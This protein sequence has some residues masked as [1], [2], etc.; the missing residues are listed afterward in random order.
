MYLFDVYLVVHVFEALSSTC[1]H[2]FSRRI[3]EIVL[4]SAC[5][6]KNRTPLHDASVDGRV[7]TARVLLEHSG[8]TDSARNPIS[9]A[10]PDRSAFL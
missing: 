7:G 3:S 10:I 4:C 1:S 8:V 2:S 9:G 5:D 6:V